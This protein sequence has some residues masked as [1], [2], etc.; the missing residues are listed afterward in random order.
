MIEWL[1]AS[2]RQKRMQQEV[3]IHLL[4]RKDTVSTAVVFYGNAH[5]KITSGERIGVGIEGNRMYFTKDQEMFKLCK[6]NAYG[7]AQICL[8]GKKEK[9]VG[10]YDLQ[11]D[12]ER[13]MWYVGV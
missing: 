1:E 2:N 6:Y 3:W 9:F 11:F 7:S 5:R 13:K 4:Q 8:P 10:Y 12:A